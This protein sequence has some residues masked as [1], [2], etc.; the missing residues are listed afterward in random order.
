MPRRRQRLAA[1]CGARALSLDEAFAADAVLI[2]SPTPTHA[3]YIERAAAAGRAIFCEKP[4]DLAAD[5]CVRAWQRCGGPA[6]C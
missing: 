3:D 5:G 4:I 1:A 2:G 6:W